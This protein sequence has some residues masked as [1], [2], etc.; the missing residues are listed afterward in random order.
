MLGLVSRSL[1]AL[2]ET[3]LS[4]PQLQTVLEIG[5]KMSAVATKLERVFP[6]N[7]RKY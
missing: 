2:G 5:L 6:Y 4:T 3:G 7:G 1:D